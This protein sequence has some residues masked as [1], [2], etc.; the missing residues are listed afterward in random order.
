MTI[1]EQLT[2]DEGL[3]LK[4]Y[5]DTVGKLTIGVGRNLTD[6]GISQTEAE[7]MLANDIAEHTAELEQHLPWVVQLDGPRKGVLVNMCFNMGIS[8]LLGFINTLA[9]I[10]AGEYA[11]AAD[12]ML[13]SKWATQVGPRATRLSEQMRTGVWV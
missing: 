2:R 4:P 10:K 8:R 5:Y 13:H 6:K 3:R 9:Y 11:K 12:G 1:V 7:T